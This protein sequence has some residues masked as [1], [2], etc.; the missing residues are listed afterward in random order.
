MVEC[1]SDSSTTVEGIVSV[2]SRMVELVG[3]GENI[4]CFV[5]DSL[6]CLTL[7]ILDCNSTIEGIVSI[8]SPIAIGIDRR[9]DI[10]DF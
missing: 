4:P 1:V 8:F 10:A 2:A 5:I 6:S 3:E 7:S 9:G